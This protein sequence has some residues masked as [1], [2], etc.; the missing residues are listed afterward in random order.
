MLKPS[1]RNLTLASLLLSITSCQ[2]I[3]DL[4]IGVGGGKES[5]QQNTQISRPHS[6]ANSL[7]STG[8]SGPD[9][10]KPIEPL[11]FPAEHP[12]PFSAKDSQ[13]LKY[14]DGKAYQSFY[15]KGIN[16]G[17]AVPGTQA[18]DL[19][20]TREEYARWFKRIT[21]LGFNSLRI[22]TL[23]YPRFYEE[24][25]RY[26]RD[27]PDKP[28]YLFHGV[29]L[30]EEE[31]I[32][33]LYRSTAKF[34]EGIK[35]VI[36]AVHGNKEIGERRGRAYGKYEAD[37]S[38]W[39]MAWIIGREIAPE[40]NLPT[41]KAHAD[42]TSYQGK[43]LAIKGNPTEVWATERM[44]KL[45][46]Y[47]RSNY[48]VDRAL[49][50]SSWPTLDPLTHPTE[51]D[52]EENGE[53]VTSID[54]A[55]LELKDAPG[56]FFVNFHAYPY[57]P[58]FINDEPSYLKESDSEGVNNYLGYVKAL[59][60]HYKDIPLV[61]GEYGVPSSWGNAHFSPSGMHH[62]GHDEETQQRYNA[63]MTQNIYDSGA[64]GGMSFAW[65]DEWWKR[66]WIVDPREMPRERYR[67]W[68]NLTSPEENF[69]MIAFE[70]AEP[71]FK[72]LG[73]GQGRI[74]EVQAAHDASF[75]YARLKLSAPLEKTEKLL[76]GYDTYG[77][78]LGENILPNKVK[79]QNRLEFAL[80][81]DNPETAQLRVTQA[82]DL[83]GIWH[84]T[85]SGLQVYQSVASEGKPWIPVR[86]QN[87]AERLSKDGSQ[88]F[89]LTTFDIGKLRVRNTGAKESSQ[90]A[91]IFNGNN[92]DIR[93][94]WNML[95]FT[96]P[97]TL[98]VTHDDR[99]TKDRETAKSEGIALSISLANELVETKRYLWPSWDQAPAVTEREKAG[100]KHMQDINKRLPEHP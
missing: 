46:D 85:S 45:I 99:S 42:K 39:V 55:Q 18:G 76:V 77:D 59:K 4:L 57:Y 28:L 21:E 72:S 9:K 38:R 27:N 69:G 1:L 81:V 91:V 71:V 7:E 44:D 74:Q 84:G 61:I 94:P 29:W 24:L 16:L 20:A 86:W 31:D 17:V 68:H 26:N 35:E 50:W 98:S 79:T 54:L 90:D 93:I 12:V 49:S 14:W 58:N 6:P 62:G 48:K 36:D 3:D 70:Q 34:D 88:T 92:I 30:D 63:R 8:A 78:A 75:F 97:S 2:A 56:G 13:Y 5:V 82:Y 25:A 53:D 32:G 51:Q 41:N 60:N 11:L 10:D 95:Q 96:D 83:F 65:I 89:P 52:F 87:D 66:T 80:T 100:L 43:H 73:K 22:Y 23:H 19:A 40:E 15:I 67:L 64:A 37:V 33:D 47:E